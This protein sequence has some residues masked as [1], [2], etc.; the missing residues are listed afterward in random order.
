MMTICRVLQIH[1]EVGVVRKGY[2]C[3]KNAF[4]VGPGTWIFYYDLYKLILLFMWPMLIMIFAYTI[5]AIKVWRVSDI[6]AGR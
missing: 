2:W 6:R 4:D 5:I 1:L 3:I